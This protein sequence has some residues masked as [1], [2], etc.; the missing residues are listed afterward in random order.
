MASLSRAHTGSHNAVDVLG[1]HVEEF[2]E[3]SY[4][5]VHYQALKLG[6]VQLHVHRADHLL[7]GTRCRR[8]SLVGGGLGPGTSRMVPPS[9]GGLDIVSPGRRGILRQELRVLSEMGPQN[10]F[11]PDLVALPLEPD[12]AGL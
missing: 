9:G 6:K 10:G 5:D 8:P 12:S 7:E 11:V 4:H 1:N 3:V 2:R